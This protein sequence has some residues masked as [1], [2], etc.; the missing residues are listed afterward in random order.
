MMYAYVIVR[1]AVNSCMTNWALKESKKITQFYL[2]TMTM[3]S[4]ND[5]NN[6]TMQ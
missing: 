5:I 4:M 2:Q 3:A 1:L 6:F